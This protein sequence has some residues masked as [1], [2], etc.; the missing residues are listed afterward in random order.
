M[1]VPI[2]VA[3]AHQLTAVALLG[4]TVLSAHAARYASDL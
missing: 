2:A 4:A 1:S 3:A